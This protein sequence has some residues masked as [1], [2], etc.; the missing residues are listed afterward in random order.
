MTRIHTTLLSKLS[1]KQKLKHLK[2][3]LKKDKSGID[4]FYEAPPSGEIAFDKST[5]LQIAIWKK[6]FAITKYLAS[7]GA[8]CSFH[9]KTVHPI[10]AMCV[11]YSELGFS[12]AAKDTLLY[13]M[14]HYKPDILSGSN[15]VLCFFMKQLPI[16]KFEELIP[17]DILNPVYLCYASLSGNL[18]NVQELLRRGANVNAVMPNSLFINTDQTPL[19]ASCSAGH[20]EITKALVEAGANLNDVY[21]NESHSIALSP[22][23]E[24]IHRSWHATTFYLLLKGAD[25]DQV[26]LFNDGLAVGPLSAVP[27]SDPKALGMTKYLLEKSKYQPNVAVTNIPLNVLKLRATTLSFAFLRGRVDIAQEL[28]KYPIDP[29]IEVKIKLIPVTYSDEKLG[30]EICKTH[31]TNEF[32]ISDLINCSLLPLVAII[33]NKLEL[34]QKI[35]M[36]NQLLTV[37]VDLNQSMNFGK[38]AGITPLLLSVLIG[39]ESLQVTEKLLNEGANPNAPIQAQYFTDTSLLHIAIANN[40]LETASLLIKHGVLL[41]KED[42]KGFTPL[43]RAISPDDSGSPKH[44]FIRLLLKHKAKTQGII[45]K[46]DSTM[47]DALKSLKETDPD[48]FSFFDEFVEF[49]PNVS[50]ESASN[51]YFTQNNNDASKSNFSMSRASI[52]SLPLPEAVLKSPEYPLKVARNWLMKGHGILL[53]HAQFYMNNLQ[54]LVN[55]KPFSK[56]RVALCILRG[57]EALIQYIDKYQDESICTREIA[58]NFRNAVMHLFFQLTDNDILKIANLTLNTISIAVDKKIS[59]MNIPSFELLVNDSL[60]QK[61]SISTKNGVEEKLTSSELIN[62]I[63]THLEEILKYNSSIDAEHNLNLTAKEEI[64]MNLALIGQYYRLLKIKNPL[65]NDFFEAFDIHEQKQSYIVFFKR[66]ASIRNSIAHDFSKKTTSKQMI[67]IDNSYLYT[68]FIILKQL[69]GNN[70][71]IA[72]GVEKSAEN[73]SASELS[74]LMTSNFSS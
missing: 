42:K 61:I 4:T 66:C 50:T 19:T 65:L 72:K 31:F 6:D 64:S 14:N 74:Y 57:Y 9:P 38:M 21:M 67:N 49:K 40:D 30:S 41:E 10:S 53:H 54:Q 32:L 44:E 12:Q 37:K 24:A 29:N 2:E 7:Q 33:I 60:Y 68:T 47:L 11:V 59:Y 3:L 35:A 52:W 8:S 45:K 48:I 18:K 5:P 56:N 22:L 1:S 39:Q 17:I 70:K 20:Y 62:L 25:P 26:I 73:S 71:K 15:S 43:M 13:L 16:D 51:G 34:D 23:K 36:I 69:I 46:A 28:L 27:F 55:H 58:S 63:R